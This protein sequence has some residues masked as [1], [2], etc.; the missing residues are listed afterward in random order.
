LTSSCPYPRAS[1]ATS[2]AALRYAGEVLDMQRSAITRA[3]VSGQ[4]AGWPDG[5]LAA[6]ASAHQRAPHTNPRSLANTIA[7]ERESICSFSKMFVR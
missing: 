5:Q 1:R 3:C 2:P 7:F 6:R 4:M